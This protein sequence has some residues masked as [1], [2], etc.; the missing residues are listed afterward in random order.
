MDALRA[1]NP[2]VLLARCEERGYSL[3]DITPQTLRTQ[4]RAV[5]DPLNAD[6]PVYTLAQFVV[7]SGRAGPVAA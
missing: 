1:H 3:V 6:S 7:E 4:L 5:A 2:Q